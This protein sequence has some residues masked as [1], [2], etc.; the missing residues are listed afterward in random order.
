MPE[1]MGALSK[2][3]KPGSVALDIIS[4]VFLTFLCYLSIG[5]PLA[6]LPTYVHDKLGFSTILAGVAISIQYAATTIS[7]PQVGQMADKSGAKNATLIGFST[8]LL[9]GGGLFLAGLFETPPALGLGILLI[10]RLIQGVSESWSSTG[11][12][13]WALARVGHT[14]T[15]KV[16]SWNGIA[17]YGGLSV[18]APLG[19]VL[20]QAFGFASL[21]L[22]IL[23]I[24]LLGLILSLTKKGVPV[25]AQRRLGFG[26]VFR[27]ILP[28]GLVLAL[29]STGFGSI[30]AFITLFFQSRHWDGAAFSLSLFGL[31][32]IAVRLVFSQAINLFGGFRVAFVSLFFQTLGLALL[33]AAPAPLIAMGGAS[34]AGLG[35]SLV[36]PALGVE[37]VERVPPQNRGSAIGAYSVFLDI[38]LGVTGPITGFLVGWYG[39]ASPFLFA[40]LAAATA[41]AGT[42]VLYN[43]A[44]PR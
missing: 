8:C 2:P 5:L 1:K 40:S 18:G 16:I 13:M 22:S 15:A 28:L 32:F 14:H 33:W 37:A 31:S 39:F 21:G 23:L 19:V 6:V 34:L 12:M 30:A 3:K 42:F 44:R 7:R 36:F 38:S 17:S 27:Q 4:T 35:F 11:A 9:S 41:M 29:A 43:R 10:A 25:V 24:G 26:H 20:T